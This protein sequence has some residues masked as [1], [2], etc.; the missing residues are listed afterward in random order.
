MMRRLGLEPDPWQLQVLESDHPR[1][2]LNCCRQA[3]KSTVVAV[4]GLAEA[5]FLPDTLVLLLARSHRQSRVLF[6]KVLDFHR[7]LG[8]PLQERRTTDELFLSNH[9]RIVSLPCREE[10]IR[11]YSGVTLLLI[12]EASRVPDH[13]YRAVRPMLAASRGRLIALSTPYGRRGFFYQAWADSASDWLRIEVPAQRIGRIPAEFLEEE[14]RELGASWF[15][16]EYCCS[17]E[18]LEGLVYPDFARCVVP[19]PAPTGGKRVGGIDFGYRNPFAAVWGVLDRDDVLWLTG[20]HYAAQKPLEYHA[21]RLPRDV[22]WYCDP[23]GAQERIELLAA[24][25]KVR[26]GLNPIRPGVMAVSA[27]LE[28]GRL[29]VVAGAC[30]K[31]LYEAALYRYGESAEGRG[32]EE[33]VDEHNHAVAALRYLISRLDQ[34]RL[35][36]RSQSIEPAAA[37]EVPA[38]PPG[39]KAKPSWPQRW[40]N[41]D[42]WTRIF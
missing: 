3:G 29:R 18:A 9:S 33:P 14:R 40:T 42:L 28:S 35:G 34:R 22:M 25:L 27:R 11:G 30:P 17:F 5:L 38:A 31:L 21:A 6:Q 26:A 41:E 7:A 37:E 19:G 2:L 8:N 32:T 4:L 39:P 13:V 15:R 1:Q 24:G 23:S 20:E 12:D 10:T 16:Q 36:R